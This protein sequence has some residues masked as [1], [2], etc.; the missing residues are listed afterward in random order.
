MTYILNED[1]HP[2]ASAIVLSAYRSVVVSCMVL[3]YYHVIVPWYCRV[4]TRALK[5]EFRRNPRSD[6]WSVFFFFLYSMVYLVAVAGTL[7][8]PV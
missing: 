6:S 8:Y 7:G 3:S 2:V 5:V 4:I 1:T